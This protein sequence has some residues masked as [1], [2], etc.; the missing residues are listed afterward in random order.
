[1]V[2]FNANKAG[3]RMCK[4]NLVRRHPADRDARGRPGR[5]WGHL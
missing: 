2:R 3:G 4:F 1:V 5:Q